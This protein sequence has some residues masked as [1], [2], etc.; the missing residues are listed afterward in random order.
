MADHLDFAP[1]TVYITSFRIPDFLVA[2]LRDENFKG[3][4]PIRNCSGNPQKFLYVPLLLIQRGGIHRL[5]YLPPQIS[6]PR[7]FTLPP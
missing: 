2:C 5:Q 1:V 6:R 3:R 4:Y 7:K